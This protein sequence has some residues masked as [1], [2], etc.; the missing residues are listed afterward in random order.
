MNFTNAAPV[1]NSIPIVIGMKKC[2]SNLGAYVRVAKGSALMLS[3]V[4]HA[5]NMIYELIYG[6][7]ALS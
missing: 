7:N 6:V 4:A 2:A 5:I 3:C 1:Q